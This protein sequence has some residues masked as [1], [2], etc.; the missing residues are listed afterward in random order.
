MIITRGN[1]L[2]I[3]PLID[4]LLVRFEMNNQG[5]IGCFLGLE[6]DKLENGYLISQKGYARSLLECFNMGESKPMTTP[7]KLNLKMKKDQGKELKDAKLFQQL[8]GTKRILRYVKGS[9]GHNWMGDVNDRHS[10][11][12]YYFNMGFAVI[13]WCN[14]KQ[15]VVALS[16]TEAEYT[17]ATMAARV[18]LV[19]NVDW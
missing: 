2:E 7:M 10:T 3:S 18:Y 1:V 13:S 17:P 4:D 11:S 15:D 19:K 12:G 6:A 8:V 9:M 5:E 16:S 14:K